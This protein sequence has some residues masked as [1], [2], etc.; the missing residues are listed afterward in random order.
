MRIINKSKSY[1]LPLLDEFVQIKYVEYVYNT[2][3]FLEGEE[4]KY[5]VIQYEDNEYTKV[6]CEELDK[7]Y[8]KDII[9]R[10]DYVY[11]IFKVPEE[12]IPDYNMFLEGRFSEIINK[13]K[14]LN[15]LMKNYG[16]RYYNAINRIKQVLYRDK[17]LRAEL[18]F[19]LDITLPEDVELSSI[20]DKQTETIR[21]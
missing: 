5:I 3:L 9:F 10:D 15:F 11:V 6:Y 7:D 12:I 19:N 14:I 21:L 8:I 1:V 20:P 18:E 17:A 4:N 16:S 13:E 2:Y